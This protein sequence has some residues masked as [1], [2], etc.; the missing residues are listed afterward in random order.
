MISVIVPV[1]NCEKYLAE[2]LDS[3]I[4]QTYKDLEII[5]VNDGSKDSSLDILKQYTQND[6]R[7]IVINK[8]NGGLSSARNAGLKVAKG[9]YVAFVDGDDVL[10]PETYEQALQ[11][12]ED[13]DVVCFGV[14]VFGAGCTDRRQADNEYYKIKF[15]GIIDVSKEV[16]FNTDV[17]SCNKIFKMN[18]IKKYEI[19]YPEGLRYEDACFY[20]KYM[21]FAKKIK[22]F[23]KYFYFYR[24]HNESIMANTFKGSE[25]AIDH[26]RVISN[27]Q[28]F[29]EKNDIFQKNYEMFYQIYKNFFDFAFVFSTENKKKAVLKLAKAYAKKYFPN[30]DA[31]EVIKSY[32][33]AYR[34]MKMKPIKQILKQIFSVSNSNDKKHKIVYIL[35]LKFKIRQVN[36]KVIEEF[37]DLKRQIA[38]Q[39]D[40]IY[41]NTQL[42]QQLYKKSSDVN[43]DFEY[44]FSNYAVMSGGGHENLKYLFEQMD[45]LQ[46][47]YN[48]KQTPKSAFVWGSA[49]WTPQADTIIYAMNQNIPLYKFEDGFLRSADTWC[50]TVVDKKYTTGISFTVTDSVHYFDATRSSRMEQLLNDKFLVISDEHKQRARACIDRIVE[51]HLTKYN[52]QPI[53]EPKIGRDGVKKVL[54]IDQSFGDFSISRGLASENTFKEMLDAAIRENPD[55]DIIVKTHPDTIAKGSCRK[56][57]YYSDLV[58]HDNVYTQTEAINPISLIKYVDKVYVCTTQ[59]GFEALMCGKEVHVFGMPFYAGWG[60]THDR[61]KCERR[62]NTRTLE[63]VFYIAYIMYSYYVNPEKQCR[64][65]IEEAM[66]Y[67]LKLRDEYFSLQK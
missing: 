35:G 58:A 48:I 64:C 41:E 26:L 10:A 52:H 28:I 31:I 46:D 60:L 54:V 33:K 29:F 2:C 63:E 1:Y 32:E 43:T 19:T 6:S 66:D 36:K 34:Q 24:R 7:I 23:N 3:I 39:Q 4:A 62:T 22:F 55:A 37:E 50:N 16:L 38:K 42:I 53:F 8:E 13:V 59:F 14:K 27:L 21:S 57:G 44:A 12:I 5:C 47:Y 65:E 25:Y 51:T 17:S 45:Y 18:I 15:N 61:Q 11:D 9:E 49:A 30:T 56:T 67:L 40:L 20:W